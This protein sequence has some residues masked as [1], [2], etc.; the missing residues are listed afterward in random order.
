MKNYIKV[1]DRSE[2]VNKSHIIRMLIKTSGAHK[3]VLNNMLKVKGKREI[4]SEEIVICATGYI[5]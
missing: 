2:L 5:V 3:V 1:A 4:N